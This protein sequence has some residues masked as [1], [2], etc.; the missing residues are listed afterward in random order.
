VDKSIV[1]RVA[2]RAVAGLGL[3]NRHVTPHWTVNKVV[4]VDGVETSEVY[5]YCNE[6][7]Q[8]DNVAHAMN[9]VNGRDA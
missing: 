8:A 4:A 6:R 5:A 1:Y 2:S 9:V 3:P 7:N